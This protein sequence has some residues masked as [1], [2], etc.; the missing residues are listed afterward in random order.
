MP[1]AAH[2]LLPILKNLCSNVGFKKVISRSVAAL[3]MRC[4]IKRLC[5]FHT[6]FLECTLIHCVY[7]AQLAHFTLTFCS[8]CVTD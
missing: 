4:G 3:L 7:C 5:Y 2:K 1:V 6:Y 8:V